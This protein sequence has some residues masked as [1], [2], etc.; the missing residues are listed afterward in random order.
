MAYSR[1]TFALDLFV[2]VYVAGYYMIPL[3]VVYLTIGITFQRYTMNLFREL[4]RL[5]GVTSS[6]I[7][8]SFSEGLLG[9]KA[10]RAFGVGNKMLE[11]FMLKLDENHK[12]M[13]MTNA[14]KQ[15]FSER[16]QY[17]ALMVI[18]PSIA[19]SVDFVYRRSWLARLES[20]ISLF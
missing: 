4:T 9:C 10:I 6:P 14:G 7:I 13:I 12:N 17:M 2:A 3:V 8:Q 11:D 5:R 20:A 18:L 15:Y 1:S 16:I 19:L